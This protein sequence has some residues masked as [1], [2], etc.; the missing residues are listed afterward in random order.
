[1]I[2]FVRKLPGCIAGRRPP[3]PHRARFVAILVAVAFC[4]LFSRA[5]A[6]ANDSIDPSLIPDGTYPAHVDRVVSNQQM[7]V[8]M[9]GSLKVVLESARK[10]VTFAD[11]VK[12]NDDI[13]VTLSDGKVTAF[14]RK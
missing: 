14:T 3:S 10:N 9:Q 5:A 1:M 11:K 4:M 12:A 6:R 7:E 2:A 8:T 13:A